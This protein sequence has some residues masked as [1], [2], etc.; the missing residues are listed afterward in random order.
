MLAGIDIETTGLDFNKDS[1][2]GVGVY[3]EDGASTYG[4]VEDARAFVEARPELELCFHNAPF[5]VKFLRKN[6]WD[7]VWHHDT[8]MLCSLDRPTV[9]LSLEELS[10]Q[11]LHC[12]RWKKMVTRGKMEEE[13]PETVRTYCLLDC[14]RTVELARNRLSALDDQL[15]QYYISYCLPVERML[16]DVEYEGVRLDVGRVYDLALDIPEDVKKLEA[17]LRTDFADS[18]AVVEKALYDPPKKPEMKVYY[19]KGGDRETRITPTTFQKRKNGEGYVKWI[20]YTEKQLASYEKQLK[21]AQEAAVFNFNSPAQVGVLL[22]NRGIYPTD[23]KGKFTTGMKALKKWKDKDPFVGPFCQH[24]HLSTLATFPPQWLASLSE[25]RIHCNFNQ[26][27]VKSR[28]LSCRNPNLQQVAKAD[29]YNMRHCYLPD[30]GE[31]FL[32]VDYEQI[33]PRL[34]AHYSQ[35]PAL[36]GVFHDDLNLYGVIS[37]EVF[38]LTCHPNEV[39]PTNKMIYAASKIVFLAVSYGMQASTLAFTLAPILGRPV[40]DEE[41][42]AYLDSFYKRF[43]KLKTAQKMVQEQAKRGL[44]LSGWF[45]CKLY[46]KDWFDAERKAFNRY[47]QNAASELTVGTQVNV[48]RRCKGWASLRLLVHDQAIYS[49]KPE[50]I[51]E[52]LQILN[53]EM[54][55][56]VS[57][58]VPLKI[59]A[60]VCDRWGGEELRK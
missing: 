22:K 36:C 35:D 39:K 23:K 58:R 11:H 38:G 4:S 56:S 6:G 16:I 3:T 40:T 12:E 28:R 51:D 24:S 48:R 15:K 21:M 1:I 5:D 49:T 9:R 52:L 41:A 34:M 8:Q 31:W 25:G 45:G 54:C 57:L 46:F 59:E 43:S 53:E 32:D 44:Q 55:Q 50:R 17:Q 20:G 30:D 60:T 2:L 42:Q 26:T 14:Q 19:E 27:D 7:C 18:I 37:N 33:E 13:S 29:E 47:I 10:V